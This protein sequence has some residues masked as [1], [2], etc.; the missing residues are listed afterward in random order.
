[1]AIHK[2][3]ATA[4]TFNEKFK[5]ALLDYYGY[6]F[7]VIPDGGTL[8]NDWN[9]LNNIL[10]DYVTWSSNRRETA[11]ASADSQSMEI[12][13]FHRVFRFCGCSKASDPMYFLHT[14]AILSNS[15]AFRYEM[16]E[17]GYLNEKSIDEEAFERISLGKPL[18]TSDIAFLNSGYLSD[19]NRTPNNKLAALKN[20][21]LLETHRRK[22]KG[23]HRWTLSPLTMKQLINDGKKAS[24]EF[25]RH[26]SSLIDFYSRSHLFGEIGMYLLDRMGKQY[27]SSFRIKHDYFTQALNDFNIYDL[28]CAIGNNGWCRIAYRHG[29]EKFNT[30]LLCFPL[31]IRVSYANG[32]EYLI[33]YEPFK[34]SASALRLEF[35]DSIAF[36]SDEAVKEALVS[37][38]Y[39][40]SEKTINADISNARRSLSYAWGVSISKQQVGNA[41]KPV[42]PHTVS[43]RI[44]YDGDKE[45][46]IK[47]RLMKEHRNGRIEFDDR[48]RYIDFSA[49]V[50]DEYEMMPWV[51]SFYSRLSSC[52][53]FEAAHPFS[54]MADVERTLS[55]MTG[56]E[57]AWGMPQ[58]AFDALGKGIKATEHKMLFNEIFSA[59]YYVISDVF[60]DMSSAL[61]GGWFTEREITDFIKRSLE[62]HSEKTGAKTEQL[63]PIRIK[64]LILD[65]GI[66]LK[67]KKD[68]K[69]AYQ[70]RYRCASGTEFY[71]DIVPFS[72][73]E[74]QWIKTIIE[75]AKA[76]YF[77]TPAEIAVVKEALNEAYP[78][79]KPFSMDNVVFFDKYHYSNDAV[80]RESK[81]FAVILDSINAGMT[82]KIEY[83]TNLGSLKRG[84]FRPIV[85]EFSKRDNRFQG[86]FQSCRNN[87]ILV[88]NVDSIESISPTQTSFNRED[89]LQALAEYRLQRKRSVEV[90][91]YNVNNVVDRILMEFSPWE[92][93]CIF[94][95]KTGLYKLAI[96]FQADDE[97]ALVIR[98]MGYGT[99]IRFVDREHSIYKEIIKR[100][101]KQKELFKERELS[102]LEQRVE[103]NDR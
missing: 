53:G 80:E 62:K 46:Y 4:N 78:T 3:L 70:S 34:R 13:P 29:V 33:Y 103:H 59:Y 43:M 72:T 10:R 51:R 26:L 7:K 79:I 58:K 99:E 30:E 44:A 32:R 91:F 84:E 76:G 71:R 25:E 95:E 73:A 52:E 15:F 93:R 100:L 2:E 14:M 5:R 31:Q 83:R 88:F 8:S 18:K 20:I 57:R 97:V 35:V 39:F 28:L 45:Y 38:G 65:C 101:R 12:N 21:G 74:V 1:M 48:G 22:E 54:I 66:L 96:Y 27:K 68:G 55:Y 60:T 81:A 89:A 50:A 42:K 98:L 85:L 24:Q 64:E 75:D 102:E 23:D 16:T 87:S 61:N 9:R 11:F 56:E 36:Y 77:M 94:D 63:L 40:N 37:T 6:G 49:S 47:N 41:M 69:T 82:L 19:N 90:E 67:T 92:K 17:D 86:Y